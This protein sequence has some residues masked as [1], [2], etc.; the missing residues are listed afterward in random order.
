MQIYTLFATFVPDF[1][2]YGVIIICI[3]NKF[4][5]EKESRQK[6]AGLYQENMQKLEC[7]LNKTK[8][9]NIQL[10]LHKKKKKEET[11]VVLVYRRNSDQV[12]HMLDTSYQF[13]LENAT[14]K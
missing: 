12:S 11:A 5:A 1:Q 6:Q 9:K 2:Y 14:I 8:L 7:K 4:S 13:K 3:D 10:F